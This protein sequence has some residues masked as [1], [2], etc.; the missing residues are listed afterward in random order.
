MGTGDRNSPDNCYTVGP[1]S[2]QNSQ[3]RSKGS[4]REVFR[5][6]IIIKYKIYLSILREY[7]YIQGSVLVEVKKSVTKIKTIIN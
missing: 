7:L 2:N 6:L 5:T 3:R 4:G 1:G